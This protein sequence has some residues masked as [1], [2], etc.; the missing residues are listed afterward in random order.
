MKKQ[1]IIALAQECASDAI[2]AGG[3]DATDESGKILLPVEPMTGDWDALADALGRKPGEVEAD[4]F[5]QAYQGVVAKEVRRLESLARIR[6]AIA[7]S[8][9]SQTEVAELAGWTKQ[10]LYQ[11]LRVKSISLET[12]QDLAEA[13]DT[14]VG[15][16][17]GE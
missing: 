12:I 15:G 1:D 17:L 10:Q 13:L 4:I 3:A 7:E 9:M 14:T 16:L 8:G 11:R 6:R 5:I 2:E